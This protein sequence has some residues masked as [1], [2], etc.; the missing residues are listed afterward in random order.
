MVQGSLGIPEGNFCI[1]LLTWSHPASLL[2]PTPISSK[3]TLF[4]ILENNNKQ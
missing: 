3:V 4:V 1:E 2:S